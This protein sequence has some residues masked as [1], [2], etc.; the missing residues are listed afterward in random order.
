M[1]NF[2]AVSGHRY[3]LSARN[4][5]GDITAASCHFHASRADSI[6]PQFSTIIP[7]TAGDYL[8]LWATTS[9]Y[10]VNNTIL[11]NQVF[12]TIFKVA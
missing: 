2:V 4:A 1:A 10:A 12:F 5:L 11:A 3:G 6:T 8:E 9:N 7:M